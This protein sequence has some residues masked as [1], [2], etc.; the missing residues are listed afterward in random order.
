MQVRYK[1]AYTWQCLQHCDSL[2]TFCTPRSWVQGSCGHIYISG[3]LWLVTSFGEHRLSIHMSFGTAFLHFSSR[4]A[5]CLPNARP[6]LT[7]TPRYFTSGP[8]MVVSP[9][10]LNGRAVWSSLENSPLLKI[11]ISVFD[12]LNVRLAC[13][14]RLAA[15][16]I[17]SI[18]LFCS[19]NEVD[20]I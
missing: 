10:M 6:T 5:K 4:Y 1:A 15:L 7:C 3:L 9:K 18:T 20:H 19:V 2:L 12:W 16:S 13:Y 11:T 8:D 14:S 17:N